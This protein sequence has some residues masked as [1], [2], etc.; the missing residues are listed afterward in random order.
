MTALAKPRVAPANLYTPVFG[1]PP[2]PGQAGDGRAPDWDAL[3][4]AV[5]YVVF[6]TGRCG[7]TWLMHLL[8]DT[9]LCGTP[10]EF[11]NEGGIASWN[12]RIGAASVGAYIEGLA[13]R[14]GSSG[15]FG[16]EIDV[17]RF[18]QLHPYLDFNRSFPSG[19]TVFLWMT[20]R[21]ILAQA[22]SFATAKASGRWHVFRGTNPEA[23][24]PDAP[25]DVAIWQEIHRLLLRE[26][27][28]TAFFA[29]QELRVHS[30]AYEDL[31]A[32]RRMVLL[33][34]LDLLGCPLDAA[35]AAAETGE[36]RTERNAHAGKHTLLA[37]FAHRHRALLER[38]TA[39][40]DSF[41]PDTL[42]PLLRASAGIVL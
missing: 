9:G 15:R 18:F 13:R 20:R 23:A 1:E 14:Y 28:M 22:Y 41:D 37:G 34:V 11:F 33:R 4:I 19:R 35:L 24:T 40:R 42:A 10:H 27:R 32:D 2:A 21:D 12:R 7:S 6:M 8:R 38:V 30:I 36:D 5:P 3:G 26:R 25:A 16:F 39:E 31:V 17:W 29:A